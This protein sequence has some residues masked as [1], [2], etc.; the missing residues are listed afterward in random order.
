M[1]Y[2]LASVSVYKLKHPLEIFCNYRCATLLR[3]DSDTVVLGI[4][5]NCQCNYFEEHLRTA[6]SFLTVS[7]A[8]SLAKIASSMTCYNVKTKRIAAK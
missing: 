6:A 4:L 5:Q 1:K 3:R 8:N 7:Q 2:F